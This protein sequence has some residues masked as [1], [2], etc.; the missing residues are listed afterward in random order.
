MGLPAV[1]ACESRVQQEPETPHRFDGFCL[2][3]YR[4]EC[5]AV[6][7]P[8]TMIYYALKV[9]ISAALIVLVS[10]LAKRDSLLAALVASL[11]VTSLLAFVWLYWETGDAARV[12]SLSL[13]IFW[14]VIPSLAL[15]LALPLFLRMAWGFWISLLAAIAVTTVCYVILFS[16]L[17][18]LGLRP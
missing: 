5:F 10:E 7:S 8:A 18:Y 2:C 3:N 13:D 1:P 12:S 17:R 15:F 9:L 16:L 14:L 11:P 6:H 4:F